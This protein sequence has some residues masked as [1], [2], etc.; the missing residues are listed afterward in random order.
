VTEVHVEGAA[1]L[2]TVATELKELGDG[3]LR[4]E[5][6]KAIRDAAKPM[7][8]AVHES[9]LSKLPKRGGLNQLVARAT[10]STAIKNGSR[11]AGVQLKAVNANA[12]LKSIDAGSVRHPVFGRRAWVSQKV[13]PGSFTDPVTEHTPAVQAAVI[14]ALDEMTSKIHG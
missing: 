2:H 14:K 3:K 7:K 11:S 4:R 8:D 13:T 6:G 5:L 1:K 10:I 12:S 9:F